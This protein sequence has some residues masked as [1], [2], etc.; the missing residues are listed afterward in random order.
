M[1]QRSNPPPT[2]Q[3]FTNPPT[4]QHS[5]NPPMHQRSSNALALQRSTNAPTL[6]QCSYAHPTPQRSSAPKLLRS[7]NALMP[8]SVITPPESGSTL[9]C[10]IL[11]ILC[12]LSHKFI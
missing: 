10:E 11:R 5:P 12:N 3:P 2:P 8:Y 7:T 4:L 1:L 9:V 6:L